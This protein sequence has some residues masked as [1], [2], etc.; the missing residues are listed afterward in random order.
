MTGSAKPKETMVRFQDGVDQISA[1]KIAQGQFQRFAEPGIAGLIDVNYR[2]RFA[3]GGL[4]PRMLIKAGVTIRLNGFQGI[5][6][7]LLVHVTDCAVDFKALTAT[8]SVRLQVPRPA[9]GGGS[10]G[11]H[12]GRAYPMRAL[13]VGKYA[14]TV[15][16]LVLPWSY[17]KVQDAYLWVPRSSFLEKL[18]STATF[19]YEEFTTRIPTEQPGL[20]SVLH[21]DRSD[22]PH[23]LIEE[24]VWSG[25]R[26]ED[27]YVYPDP[28]GA[29]W[30]DPFDSAGGV[31]QGRACAA[32]EIPLLVYS[33]NGVAADAM[34]NFPVDPS[35]GTPKFLHPAG[36]TVNYGV[37]QANPFFEGAWEQVDPDGTTYDSDTSLTAEGAGLIV[38]WGNYYEPAG[39]S[40]GRFS[41]GAA[42]TGKLE[43]TS[44]WTWDLSGCWTSSP[45]RTTLTRSTPG[46]CSCRSSVM[47]KVPSRC[48]SWAGSPRARKELGAD[49]EGSVTDEQAEYLASR[50]CGCCLD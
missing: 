15:Q 5:Q 18:T 27:R 29:E 43:D 34:P 37:H 8:L 40:P 41:K 49:M 44:S 47:I 33:G 17:R 1:L 45:L 50:Y 20:Q 9:H 13:Q 21:Q 35:G 31:R 11:S 25:P 19:P 12:E 4:C 26:R 42:R 39:Y 22:E 32:S 28:D 16:D 24:L 38:G 48:T 2:P 3:G 46:C 14:N 36:V 30:V 10:Q 6:G 23:G 7:G